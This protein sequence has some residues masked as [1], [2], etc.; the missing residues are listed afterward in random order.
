[1]VLMVATT[2]CAAIMCA[3]YPKHCLELAKRDPNDERPTAFY[4]IAGL[5]AVGCGLLINFVFKLVIFLL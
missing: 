5:L 1:M 2:Y 4:L 3:L